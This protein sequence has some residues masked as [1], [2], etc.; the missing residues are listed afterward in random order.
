MLERAPARAVGVIVPRRQRGYDGL[1]DA[2]GVHCT[3]WVG[4][5]HS[6]GDVID[7]PTLVADPV[8]AIEVLI[9]VVGADRAEMA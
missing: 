3:R 9:R 5:L 8:V 4:E 7:I 1:G 2:H 6:V